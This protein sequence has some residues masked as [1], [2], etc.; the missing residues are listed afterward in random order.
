MTDG[1]PTLPEVV[2]QTIVSI[3]G[4]LVGLI[5]FWLVFTM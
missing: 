3:G 1:F 4:T 5:L 2:V